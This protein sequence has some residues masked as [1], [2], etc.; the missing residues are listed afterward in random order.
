MKD[1]REL[2]GRINSKFLLLIFIFI[3]LLTG[4]ELLSY[5]YQMDDA[6]II[7]NNYIH[8]SIM[9]RDGWSSFLQ[10]INDGYAELWGQQGRFPGVM[11][12]IRAVLGLLITDVK[13]HYF[14][15]L[16]FHGVNAFLLFFVIQK[17]LKFDILFSLI[18]TAFFASCF[19]LNAS[20]YAVGLYIGSAYVN[21]LTLFLILTVLVEKRVDNPHLFIGLNVLYFVLAIG[22]YSIIV[23]I[24]SLLL[25]TYVIT[26]NTSFTFRYAVFLLSPIILNLIVT[27]FA[28]A[29][30]YIGTQANLEPA[31][32][33]NNLLN[34]S[35]NLLPNNF[36]FNVFIFSFVIISVFY[37]VVK[38]KI[39]II[40]LIASVGLMT[41][42]VVIYSISSRDS[43]PNPYFI[44]IP[45]AGLV[46][47]LV[48]SANVW[49]RKCK[50]AFALFSSLCVL[51]YAASE[52]YKNNRRH[53]SEGIGELRQVFKE[54]EMATIEESPNLVIILF[55]DFRFPRYP[56]GFYDKT[57][58]SWRNKKNKTQYVIAADYIN[59]N[60]HIKYL[61]GGNQYFPDFPRLMDAGEIF[62]ELINRHG[63]YFSSKVKSIIKVDSDNTLS[64][65]TPELLP[66]RNV[67]YQSKYDK[68][69]HSD[70][71]P[72]YWTDGNL[73]LDVFNSPS[74]RGR[75]AMLRFTLTSLFDDKLSIKTGDELKVIPVEKGKAS[76]NCLAWVVDD[77]KKTVTIHSDKT[78]QPPRDLRH[79]SFRIDANAEYHLI[80]DV[81]PIGLYI[82]GYESAG[83][84]AP[85]N[86]YRWTGAEAKIMLDS[87]REAVSEL[88]VRLF[89]AFPNDKIPKVTLNG[90]QVPSKI[91]RVSNSELIFDF[92]ELKD[93][94]EFLS[95]ATDSFIPGNGDPR[96]LGFMYHGL[97]IIYGGIK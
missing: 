28:P 40:L 63:F 91:V 16:V 34:I 2:I 81:V 41:G 85:E 17:I 20:H 64:V 19:A 87:C 33:F 80:K 66:I 36:Y 78:I 51:Q 68:E 88:S 93:Q 58:N 47:L 43:F 97:E 55:E 86:G 84:Y 52:P 30:G 23:L 3:S 65:L 72:F 4:I 14:L 18:C 83:F 9:S 32:I 96:E 90:E 56:L 37:G 67:Q 77:L 76:Y 62:K 22:N 24:P 95:F 75:K 48:I 8:S 54:I 35:G 5:D 69:F 57:I 42:Y 39:N 6:W 29:S 15:N 61:V 53:S 12:I 44:Y 26:K 38:N 27:S 45:Y 71:I 82:D 74:D 60:S 92:T 1:F 10:N 50:V 94:A 31:H 7:A 46:L 89:G 79:L 13:V 70:G 21:Y 49:K 25:F 11:P 73:Q 59:S